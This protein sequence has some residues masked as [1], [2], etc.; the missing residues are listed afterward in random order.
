MASSTALRSCVY[1][2]IVC[3]STVP[4]QTK[5]HRQNFTVSWVKGQ[6]E[7]Q[8]VSDKL[9][10][11]V[12]NPEETETSIDT[13][14]SVL[15]F[16]VSQVAIS[17][18]GAIANDAPRWSSKWDGLEHDSWEPYKNLAHTVQ[19]IL[20]LIQ[21]DPTLPRLAKNKYLKMHDAFPCS[22]FFSHLGVWLRV[23]F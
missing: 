7:H 8:Q 6:E 13:E 18:A 16:A 5:L 21:L 10:R 15:A 22:I 14:T 20:Y 2:R 19:L 12:S 3:T 4:S 1:I 9:S 17:D 11:L 23:G